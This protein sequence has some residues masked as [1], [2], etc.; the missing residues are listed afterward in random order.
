MNFR[1]VLSVLG[2][3]LVILGASMLLPLG[4]SLLYGEPDTK[5]ILVSLAVTCGSGSLLF[6]CCR[7]KDQRNALT[8]REGFLI[9]SLGWI[10]ASLFGS[11]P[12]MLQGIL[13]SFTDA[14]F[15]TM[16]GFT[17]TGATVIRNIDPLPHGILLWRALTHWLGGMGIIILAVA[18]LP[19]LGVGGRQ[20]FKAEVPGAIKDKLTPRIVETARALWIIYIILSIAEFVFLLLGGMSIFDSVCHA[21]ATMATGGFSTRDGSVGHYNSAYIDAV[22]TI[23]MAIAGMNFTL[24]Y[25]LLT[26]DVRSCYRDPELRFY[27]GVIL[28]ATVIVTLDLRI[29]IFQSLETAFRFAVFQVVAVITTTGF[30]TDNFAKW[31]ALSQVI[32]LILMFIGGSQGST[33]G[34]IKCIRVLLIFKQTY[35]ELY[36][37]IHPHAVVRV[38]LGQ[39]M[40]PLETMQS[41][42][43]FFALYLGIAVLAT[44]LMSSLGLD[45]MTSFSSVAATLGNVGPGLGLVHPATT[46]ADIPIAGKWVLSFCMLAGRLELYTIIIL[47]VP[48]FWKK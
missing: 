16:S 42:W 44:V 7:P 14:F 37:L 2:G 18:I 46:Y 19:F 40:I 48:E 29:H 47:L 33:G 24:H 23:F 10:S 3:F 35:K 11:L 41:V 15:E 43:G 45:M 39:Q 30:I 36:R 4:C 21:F 28:T 13:P 9:V 25:C 8:H 34:A 26:G 5:A 31:P 22:I 27:L 12:Y 1:N 17:T 20:L 6:F 38:K 32:L